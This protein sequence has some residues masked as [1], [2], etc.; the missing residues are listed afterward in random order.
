MGLILIFLAEKNIWGGFPTFIIF[1]RQGMK[2]FFF[3][4]KKSFRFVKLIRRFWLKRGFKFVE[5]GI[6]H[7]M[8]KF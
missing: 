6:F 1:F 7:Q 2:Q 5:N 4:F 3:L 8:K